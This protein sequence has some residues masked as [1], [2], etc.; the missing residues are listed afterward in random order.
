MDTCRFNFLIDSEHD[1]RVLRSLHRAPV[2]GVPALHLMFDVGHGVLSA[3]GRVVEALDLP[4]HRLLPPA[5]LGDAAEVV[6]RAIRSMGVYYLPDE[7]ISRIDSTATVRMP[8]PAAGWSMLTG[9]QALD[10]PRLKPNVIGRPPETVKWVTA[11][12]A[13]TRATAYDKGHQLGTAPR[14]V[15]IRLEARSRYPAARRMRVSEWRSDDVRENFR[16]R[17]E[18]MRASATGLHVMT[19]TT[20]R[21]QL[22]SFVEDGRVTPRQAERLLGHIA[23]EATGIRREKTARWRARR[24]LR[25]LGLALALDGA[26]GERVD[27]ELGQVLDDVLGA[28]VW[29]G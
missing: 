7:G 22:R 2:E 26:E 17:F 5:A 16:N 4:A 11:K 8:T 21:E 29:R 23:C 13:A 1:R 3:E 18:P 24:E 12:R 25:R 27:V 6:R 19:E 20:V 14:G 28:E 9:M 10:V 15:E